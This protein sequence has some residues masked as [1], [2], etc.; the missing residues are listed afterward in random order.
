MLPHQ[1]KASIGDRLVDLNDNS[2]FVVLCSCPHSRPRRHTRS[3][4][5]QKRHEFMTV[6]DFGKHNTGDSDVPTT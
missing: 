5:N 3:Y 4:V 2:T 1:Y 6:A